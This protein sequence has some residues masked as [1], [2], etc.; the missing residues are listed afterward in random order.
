[1]CVV[2]SVVCGI[3][4]LAA[5]V[6]TTATAADM[7]VYKAPI[8]KAP[9]PVTDIWSG[10]YGGLNAGAGL[11]RNPTND[12]TV[13]PGFIAPQFATGLFTHAPAGV[14]FGLQAGWNWHVAPSWVLGVEADW[15]WSNRSETVCTYACLPASTP[16]ALLSITDQQSMPWL[17]TARGRIG[18]L[19]PGGSLL[20]ATGGAAWSHV[21]QTLIVTGDTLF[22][23]GASVAANFGQTRLGWTAG[24]GI[25]TPIAS[26]WSLKAEYLYVDLGNVNNTIVSPLSALAMASY[27]PAT[28]AVTTSTFGIHDH[29]VRLGVN[30]HFGAGG[31]EMAR[32]GGPEMAYASAAAE[33]AVRPAAW[34][35]FYGGLNAGAALAR[36]P[37][38]NPF[39]LLPS[40]IPFPV[41]GADSYTHAPLGGAAGVQL[42]WNWRVAPTWVL[43]AEIDWQWAHQT[44]SACISECLMPP[45][46]VVVIP[47]L[48][49]GI[50]DD[51]A[52]KWFGTA[53]ARVGWVAPNDALWYATGGAAWG[54]VDET[55]T[56]IAQP[57]FFAPGSPSQG[58]FSHTKAGWTAGAGVEIPLWDRWSVKAEYLY[59]DLGKVNDSFGGPLDAFQLPATA[60]TTSSIFSIHDHIVRLGVNYHIN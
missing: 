31:P 21:D 52:L 26:H 14:M 53:R 19:A 43:G 51:Q 37:T 32:A 56:L 8:S 16:P 20:Y 24:A 9:P 36:D 55:V 57:P 4:L 49:L 40:T 39:L 44:D 28:T 35:G 41:A 45:P 30:Y 3:A 23:S 47:G 13:L 38:S 42:G 48:P 29:I 46:N 10:F 58:I 5:L 34:N 50:T 54:R 6:G 18:W 60:Q 12:T 7:P 15:Q 27:G 25:E 33:T 1:M 59:V 11:A 22:A 2:R 17:A